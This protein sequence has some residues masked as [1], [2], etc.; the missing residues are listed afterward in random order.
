MMNMKKVLTQRTA[1]DWQQ[2]FELQQTSGM[3]ITKFCEQHQLTVS[4]F[5]HWRQ[6]LN[7]SE[8]KAQPAK[9]ETDSEW[10]PVTIAMP[11]TT[12]Q[13]WSI[14]LKLPG[15]VVLNMSTLA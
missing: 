3:A 13:N 1:A 12:A 9:A 11:D 5:Y 4:N 10:Q 8:V 15:G 2:L 6:K 14:E 7:T